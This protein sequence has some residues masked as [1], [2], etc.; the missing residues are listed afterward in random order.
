LGRI[1]CLLESMY[2]KNVALYLMKKKIV[3][4]T[5]LIL[6]VLVAI[7]L[8]FR[9]EK[10]SIDLNLMIITLDTTRADHIGS[11][12]YQDI[13]TPNI[14]WLARNGIQF[15]NCYTPVPLTLPAHCCLFTGKYPLGHYVRNNGT[16][17]LNEK[18]TTLAELFALK[19][20]NTY[21]VIASYVLLSR[22][23]LNQGFDVYEDSLDSREL[24]KSVKSEIIADTVYRKFK[25]W[26]KNNQKDKRFLAWI[27]FYDPH[28]PYVPPKEFVNE[29]GA[30][31]TK[32]YDGEIAFVDKYIGKIIE[33]MKAKK[34]LEKTLIIIVGDHG[35][36]FG[37]HDEYGHS[38]F[39]YEENLKVPLIFHNQQLFKES[40][41]IK[42]R[43]NL[44]DIMPTILDLYDE[45]IPTSIQGA[46]LADF[47][48]G[49]K[50]E[51]ERTIYVE[52]MYGQEEMNWAPLT[53]IIKENFKYISLPQPEL[54]DLKN[55]PKEKEN[56]FNIKKDIAKDYDNNLQDFI[57]KYSQANRSTK[58]E[59]TQ[60][61]IHHLESLGYI[62]AF[63]NES[64][65]AIDPKI[66]IGFDNTLRKI[67]RRIEEGD[68]DL[69]ESQINAI[70]T[71]TP[72]LITPIV[73][74]Q[75]YKIH[76]KRGDLAAALM[77]LEEG[78]RE[79]PEILP[80]RLSQAL[81][82]FELERYDEVVRVC[83]DILAMDPFFTR[84]Y[85]MLGDTFERQNNL[86]EALNNYKAAVELEP[87]NMLL[88]MRY[89]DLLILSKNSQQVLPL[90]DRLLSKSDVLD[91]P[92]ILY[93]IAL[94]YSQHGSVQK[95]EEV[96][97][98]IINLRPGGKYYFT[99]ASILSKNGKLN[100]ALTNMEIAINKYS[101]DLT[102]EQKQV[103]LSAIKA[104]KN[105]N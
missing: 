15:E 70:F 50:E 66:G 10:K 76:M 33:D 39:C 25:D 17:Y 65:S 22:F 97:A 36:A 52:S 27:H 51:K 7:L 16:H 4:L 32:L 18:E 96:M 24:I 56:L 78:I 6:V 71:D 48:F 90:Y 95:A 8:V 2:N 59:L 12:G 41:A 34:V 74:T 100:E 57:L 54:Y 62:S 38:I 49:K 92:D 68:L 102:D 58:R 1:E 42:N 84:V 13:E 83:N 29:E 105:L 103:A 5:I 69:A 23:G 99:Y 85:I 60:E 64:S 98:R 30:D 11:Y 94:F 63:S 88:K 86:P 61:D 37:E 20:Y 26:F 55:D 77:T 43:V 67:S 3:L 104:W 81:H 40:R 31:L 89:C 80:F 44:I 79:F 21:A 101:Q 28:E 53:G 87:E 9:K 14:D 47:L 35:E 75:L 82:F 91:N 93:K 73:Y 19:D 72:E 46:S 45:R